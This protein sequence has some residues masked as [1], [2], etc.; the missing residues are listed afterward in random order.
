MC[1]WCLFV[2]LHFLQRFLS[3]CTVLWSGLTMP[4]PVVSWA[5]CALQAAAGGRCQEWVL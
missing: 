4:G 2:A 1:L 3:P 5:R